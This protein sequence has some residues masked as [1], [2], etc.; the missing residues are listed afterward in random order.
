MP[1]TLRSIWPA[2]VG[3][4]GGLVLLWA[5]LLLALW[6]VKP[7]EVR[8][9][10]TLRVLPDVIRLLRRLAADS[11]LPRSIRVRLVLLLGYLALPVDLVPDFIPVLGYADDAIIVAFVL[12]SVV[13]AAGPQALERHWP[14]TAAGLSAVGRLARVC[15]RGAR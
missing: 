2:L 15:I 10:E 11:T 4:T 8:L 13:R 14:G 7:D 3:I 12:R 9:R 1:E 6:V 5:V